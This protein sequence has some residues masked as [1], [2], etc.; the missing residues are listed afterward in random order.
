MSP[1]LLEPAEHAFAVLRRGGR[2]VSIAS[3]PQPRPHVETH[4]IFVR[5]TGWHLSELNDL[6]ADGA[7]RPHL[8]ATFALARAAEA[9]QALEDGHVRGKIALRID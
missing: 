3:P 5:P 4:Y 2:I 7:L 1:A 9:M 8:Q 6:I